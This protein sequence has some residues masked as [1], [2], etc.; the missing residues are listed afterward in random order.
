MDAG[1][2]EALSGELR[3]LWRLDPTRAR[4]ASWM[5]HMLVLSIRK[6]RHRLNSQT[7]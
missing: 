3:D 2:V 7:R 5:I 1:A 4:A 6:R